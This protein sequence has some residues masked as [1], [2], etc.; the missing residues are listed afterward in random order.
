MSQQ[1]TVVIGNSRHDRRLTALENANATHPTEF[2][3]SI[4]SGTS[5][6]ITIPAG[7]A[8]VLNQWA[9]GV[10]AIVCGES[11]GVPDG[12]A[13]YTSSGALVTTTLD[14]SGNWALSGTPSAYP[15]DIVCAIRASPEI[16]HAVTYAQLTALI[17]SSGLVLGDQYA[18]TFTETGGIDYSAV[19]EGGG[20]FSFA[21]W[22]APEETIILTASSSTTL[23]PECYWP[24][25]P[26]WRGRY[27]V[28]NDFYAVKNQLD[29]NSAY[30]DPCI[31]QG[32]IT[33]WENQGAGDLAG[34]CLPY[35][36]YC[37]ARYWSKVG[38]YSN[39]PIGLWMD[40]QDGTWTPNDLPLFA[41]PELAQGVIA[42]GGPI[43]RTGGVA[44]IFR[45]GYHFGGAVKKAVLGIGV[46]ETVVMGEISKLWAGNSVSL[47]VT[48]DCKNLIIDTLAS[49]SVTVEGS[50]LGNGTQIMG[51]IPHRIGNITDCILME[52][53]VGGTGDLVNVTTLRGSAATQIAGG[54]ADTVFTP[55][56]ALG[57]AAAKAVEY[58]A[59]SLGPDDNYVTDA[60]KIVL[61]NTSGTNTGDSATPAET[62]ATIG[63]L[64]ANATPKTTPVGADGIG[65]S[66]SEA[67]GVLKFLSFTNLQ[68]WLAGIFAPKIISTTWASLP[69]AASADQ[70]QEYLVTD[71]GDYGYYCR[72]NG[73]RYIPTRGGFT[74]SGT[75]S[76]PVVGVAS[77]FSSPTYGNNG[78]NVQ[79]S[80]A[81]AHGLTTTPAVGAMV[82]VTWSAGTGVTGFY[83]ILS[84]DSAN[85]I[86]INLAYAA[87][88]GSVLVATTNTVTVLTITIPGQVMGVNGEI[89]FS[90][91]SHH[92]STS[93]AGRFIYGLLAG[94][95]IGYVSTASAT[96]AVGWGEQRV[97]N[98]GSVSS[99][100]AYHQ[101]IAA[102]S[103]TSK[104]LL[105]V[106]MANSFT[107]GIGLSHSGA[108]NVVDVKHYAITVNP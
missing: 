8:F 44:S 99:Q 24:A 39:Q 73:T 35:S 53:Y 42:L 43:E 28:R 36:Q 22:T 83:T 18:L 63:P 3:E 97:S 65:I 57:T 17:G 5:G 78:G 60:E 13:V 76:T 108:N 41:H 7:H 64:I 29:N 82:Y 77:S 34:S 2:F 27:T 101:P 58:F 96:A 72:S 106:N 16:S 61:G 54:A 105:S 6:T 103:A 84:V 93:T 23:Y 10:D 98:L 81:G 70:G 68:A 79:I 31:T 9:G 52:G 90:S 69:A 85:A 71:V 12:T 49:G 95:P 104:T 19:D 14:P 92:T 37:K 46:K 20:V 30:P 25:H 94:T 59:P 51:G 4:A 47:R 67:G 21:T 55:Q 74:I 80:S 88:L 87:G 75:I 89:V 26:D 107:V 86:T 40:A 91:V 45:G 48:G 62:T 1:A 11:G 32:S 33:Y 100:I 102:I 38:S 50:I 66:D 15:V 56:G